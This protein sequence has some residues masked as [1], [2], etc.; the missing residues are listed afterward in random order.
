M[1]GTSLPGPPLLLAT[2]RSDVWDLRY[3]ELI[4]YKEEHGDCNV[5]KSMRGLGDWVFNQRI[6]YPTPRG[7]CRVNALEGLKRL[8]S[9]GVLWQQIRVM[10]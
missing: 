2:K 5:P 8:G 6:S 1:I 9:H 4:D 10:C 7:T 3:K